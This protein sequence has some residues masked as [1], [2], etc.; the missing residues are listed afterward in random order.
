MAEVW[1]STGEPHLHVNGIGGAMRHSSCDLHRRGGFNVG[2]FALIPMLRFLMSDV[3]ELGV[4]YALL[5][6][7]V[8]T[9]YGFNVNEI[10]L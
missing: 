9:Q 10:F 8:F 6:L 4:N 5:W 1:C 3:Q 2:F 7:A